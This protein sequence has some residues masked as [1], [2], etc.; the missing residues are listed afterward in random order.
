MQLRRGDTNTMPNSYAQIYIHVVF[1]TKARQNLISNV[2]K[3]RLLQYIC[4]TVSG[5][6]QKVMAINCMPDHIHILLGLKGDV[7]ISDV[8]RDLKC[9]SSRWVNENRLVPVRFEWQHGFGAFSVGYSQLDVVGNYIRNQENHHRRNS[10]RDEYIEL[11]KN[12]GVDFDLRY[13]FDDDSAAPT[14]L[15]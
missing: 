3:E 10:F 12:A 13:V 4:G 15:R 9:N 2:W 6:K 14:E 7:K 5:K 11:L 8:V 1:A